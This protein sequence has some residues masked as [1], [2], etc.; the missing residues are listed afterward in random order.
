MR[1]I[2]EVAIVALSLSAFLPAQLGLGTAKS[3][4]VLG[5]SAVTNTGMSTVLGNLG[6]SPGFAVTGFPPGVVVGTVH[7][8]DAVALQAQSDANT[9]YNNLAG[10]ACDTDLTGQDLGGLTLVPGVYCF[11]SSAQLTGQLTLDAL[12]NAES[13][14]VFQIGSTLTTASSSSVL[15]TN[16]GSACN[17]FWQ[18]GSSATLGTGTDFAG[19]ILALASI[20][21]TTGADVAGRTFALNGAVTMDDNVV[22]IPEECRICTILAEVVD[23]GPGCGLALDPILTST[24]PVIGLTATLTI[25]S[26]FPNAMVWIFISD[27]GAAPMT[28]PGT[29][30]R[31]YLDIPTVQLVLTGMTDSEG[32]FTMPY[33][34]P[35]DP[36]LPGAC[37][38]IQAIVWS[39]TGPIG[40]DYLTSGLQI[41]FGCL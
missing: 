2:I 26:E 30:C 28:V 41:T 24:V 13:V 17:V 18:V 31:V 29:S 9:A 36:S 25:E 40:G 16:G 5:A 21:L 6:V 4:A 8:S 38:A 35:L 22:R 19:N 33:A 11:S 34:V 14:F 1:R 39:N 32:K 7:I 12:G 27:C 37:L 10:T 23:L 15:M 20:T 3:F